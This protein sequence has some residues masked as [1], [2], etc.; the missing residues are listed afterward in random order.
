M[1]EEI[2]IEKGLWWL[3]SSAVLPAANAAWLTIRGTTIAGS[4]IKRAWDILR[5]NEP[6]LP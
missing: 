2:T 5:G 4:M 3:A 1:D 6:S